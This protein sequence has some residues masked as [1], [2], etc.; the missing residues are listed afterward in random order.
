[1]CKTAPTMAQPTPSS[2]SYTKFCSTLNTFKVTG[3]GYIYTKRSVYKGAEYWK[4]DLR[5]VCKAGVVYKNGTWI[6]TKGWV[7]GEHNSHLPD[8]DRYSIICN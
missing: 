2:I 8:F 6:K 1:V 4:C 3:E 7:N 5:N